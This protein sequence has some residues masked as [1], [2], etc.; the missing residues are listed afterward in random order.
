MSGSTTTWT[1]ESIRRFTPHFI[2]ATP[3]CRETAYAKLRAFVQAAVRTTQPQNKKCCALQLASFPGSGKTLLLQQLQNAERTSTVPFTFVS[4]ASKPW[5]QVY[6]E[7]L[8]GKA[9]AKLTDL[10]LVTLTQGHIKRHKG[11]ILLDEADTILKGHKGSE[12]ALHSLILW[13]SQ[14]KSQCGIIYLSN[15][16]SLHA[17]PALKVLQP[18]IDV[19]ILPGYDK[20]ERKAVLLQRC[21]SDTVFEPSALEYLAA[22]THDMRRLLSIASDAMI[23]VRAR[24]QD[25]PRPLVTVLDIRRQ[26]VGTGDV[27]LRHLDTVLCAATMTMQLVLLGVLAL[28]K[29][30]SGGGVTRKEVTKWVMEVGLPRTHLGDVIGENEIAAG[31]ASLLDVRMLTSSGGVLLLNF[32]AK[33]VMSAVRA[34]GE[35]TRA[36][37][38]DYRVFM[39]APMLLP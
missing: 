9:K 24:C 34:A 31:I 12:T 37:K 18:H 25:H 26:C 16:M 33:V 2:P 35:A 6:K 19:L 10:E 23:A 21:G 36:G 1:D 14:S 30:G 15:N 13:A 27:Q 3:L 28:D 8:A 38:A 11:I 5:T 32:E 7:I 22:Q 17:S 29:A 39:A 20:E 4:C